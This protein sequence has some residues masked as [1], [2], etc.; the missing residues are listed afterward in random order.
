MMHYNKIISYS[1]T[2]CV[3]KLSVQRPDTVDM[4]TG[5]TSALCWFVG[6]GDL[7]G[8]CTSYSLMFLAPI[9]PAE[10]GSPGQM[11]TKTERVVF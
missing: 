6:G 7:T 11:S 1:Y 10:P 3:L 9:K 2:S 4:V 5:T 8:V